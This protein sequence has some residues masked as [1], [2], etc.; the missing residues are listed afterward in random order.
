VEKVIAGPERTEVV[1]LLGLSRRITP[2][3]KTKPGNTLFRDFET[4]LLLPD[5]TRLERT[6]WGAHYAGKL[7]SPLPA[8]FP[9]FAAYAAP[10]A[11]PGGCAAGRLEIPLSCAADDA[12]IEAFTTTLQPADALRHP[13]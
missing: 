11:G 8:V 5:G 12:L 6:R 13:A 2:G 1:L 7:G 10:A 3:K 9:N 4:F